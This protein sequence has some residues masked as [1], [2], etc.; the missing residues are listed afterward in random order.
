MAA[1]NRMFRSVELVVH[2]EAHRVDGQPAF[3]DPAKDTVGRDE[4]ERLIAKIEMQIFSPRSPV[5]GKAI[6]DTA[7]GRPPGAGPRIVS[8]SPAGGAL[9]PPSWVRVKVSALQANPPAIKQ[10]VVR[11]GADATARRTES[12]KFSLN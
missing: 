2:A 9:F 10:P 8:T 6:L 11:H 7:A 12:V 1:R 4:T 5:P 3:V